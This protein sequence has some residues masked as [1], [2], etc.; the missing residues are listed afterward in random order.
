MRWLIARYSFFALKTVFYLCNRVTVRV[1]GGATRIFFKEKVVNRKVAALAA[2][3]LV[4]TLVRFFWAK[5]YPQ[6][7]TLKDFS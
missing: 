3:F 6:D 4:E 5:S 2:P 1:L 7:E